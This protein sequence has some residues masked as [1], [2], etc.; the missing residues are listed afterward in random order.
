M[1]IESTAMLLVAG[2]KTKSKMQDQAASEGCTD[3]SK[4]PD[5][6]DGFFGLATKTSA[7]SELQPSSCT[8]VFC[9]T[10]QRGLKRS[11]DV[12]RHQR[13]H[14]D[15]RHSVRHLCQKWFSRPDNLKWIISKWLS[16]WII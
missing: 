15:R 9:S 6:K 2:G 12:L 10:W 1:E 4:P 5:S 14:V 8:C 13:T 7:C 11:V 3:K 16:V